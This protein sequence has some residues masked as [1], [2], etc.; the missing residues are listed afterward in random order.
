[1]LFASDSFL[2]SQRI[3]WVGQVSG[4]V[5]GVLCLP[6][7]HPLLL[8]HP[9]CHQGLVPVAIPPVWIIVLCSS[10]AATLCLEIN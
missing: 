3:G 10:L 4:Q 5:P 2:S 8:H 6:V 9:R 7:Q 1:M